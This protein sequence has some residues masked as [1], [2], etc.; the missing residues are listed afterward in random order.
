MFC[1]KQIIL[2]SSSHEKIF[3]KKIITFFHFLNSLFMTQSTH[4]PSPIGLVS[5]V[6]S[7]TVVFSPRYFLEKNF[8]LMIFLFDVLMLMCRLSCLL[9][10]SSWKTRISTF[11]E[12]CWTQS[13]GNLNN[14][15]P[16]IRL[17][18]LIKSY[19]FCV[20]WCVKVCEQFWLLVRLCFCLP[21]ISLNFKANYSSFQAIYPFFFIFPHFVNRD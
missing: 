11:Y 1:L 9:E 4:F 15:L 17:N 21:A 19:A 20:C 14:F 8:S 10:F 5:L 16:H 18:F 3:T 6:Y 7:I 12:C 2:I 13:R